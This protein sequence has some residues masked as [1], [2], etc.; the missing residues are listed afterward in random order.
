MAA[1][2]SNFKQTNE[3]IILDLLNE[4]N[5][6]SL[7]E[8]AVLF[9]TPAEV[10]EG[11]IATTLEVTAAEGS[12]Y[13]GSV[14]VG[15]N[16]VPLSFMNTSEPNLVL[17][18][19]A[20]TAH[21]LIGALNTAFGIQ[22]TVDDLVDSALPAVEPNVEVNATISATATSLVWHGPVTLKITAPLVELSTVLTVTDLDGLYPPAA[23][24][25]QG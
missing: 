11:E 1:H 3:K 20:V 14:N 8:G 17:E 7:P 16:R 19:E 25:A 10:V 18:T 5:G 2:V 13:K 24:P 21:G 9:G 15:Y 4:Q 6:A 22:L 23:E 12:G